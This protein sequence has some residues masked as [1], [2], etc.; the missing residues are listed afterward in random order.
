MR[1]DAARSIVAAF[2]QDMKK[3]AEAPL[4]DQI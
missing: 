4:S 1:P 3:G 2:W